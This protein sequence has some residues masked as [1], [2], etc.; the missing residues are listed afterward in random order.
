MGWKEWGGLGGVE[1]GG[2][3][4]SGR[5]GREQGVVEWS[6]VGR[7]EKEWEGVRER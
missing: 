7:N 3:G 2:M 1:Q 5:N 4:L 6:G